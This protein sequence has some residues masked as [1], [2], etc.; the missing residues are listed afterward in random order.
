MATTRY[1]QEFQAPCPGCKRKVDVLSTQGEHG[2]VTSRHIQGQGFCGGSLAE[3]KSSR[4][5]A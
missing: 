3:H 4:D 2:L 1:A 5:R